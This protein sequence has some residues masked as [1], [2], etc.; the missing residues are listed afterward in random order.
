M[1]KGMVVL[2][3]RKRGRMKDRKS[4]Q[5]DINKYIGIDVP[6][7]RGK[8]GWVAGW[9]CGVEMRWT[10]TRSHSWTRAVALMVERTELDRPGTRGW[11]CC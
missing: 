3:D 11:Y 5:V 10:G 9:N 8:H 6:T 1:D 7:G 2:L 4:S